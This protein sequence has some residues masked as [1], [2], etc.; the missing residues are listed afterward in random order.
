VISMIHSRDYA[1]I[2][3]KQLRQ[4]VP[5]RALSPEEVD[6]VEAALAEPAGGPAAGAA[7]PGSAPTQPP[8]SGGTEPHRPGEQHPGE[9]LK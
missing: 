7:R 1:R 5:D 9:P 4:S 6:V 8:G 2:Y 3:V